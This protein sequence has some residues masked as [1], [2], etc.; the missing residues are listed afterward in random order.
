MTVPEKLSRAVR[1]RAG[2]GAP[3]P[4][5]YRRSVVAPAQT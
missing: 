4:R 1:A 3:N 2:A 5:R